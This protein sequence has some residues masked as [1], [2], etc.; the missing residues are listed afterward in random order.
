MT[1]IF[2]YGSSHIT[3][4]PYLFI[5]SFNLNGHTSHVHDFGLLAVFKKYKNRG[6]KTQKNKN[7]S[8]DE[9]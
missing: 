5:R 3:T 1:V 7:S 6:E 9:N 8:Q 2:R 4:L